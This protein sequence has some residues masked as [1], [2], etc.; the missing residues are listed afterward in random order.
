MSSDIAIKVENLSKI[1]QIYDR[2]QDRLKQSIFLRLNR[3][4]GRPHE[5]YFKQFSAL[6]NVSFE[7]KKGETVGI[8]GQNGSGKS[9]LLQMI[10]GTLNPTQGSISVKG[11][12]AALLELGAGFNTE[13]TGRENVYTNAALLGLSRGE[14][15]CK[16]DAIL[17]FADIGLFID[18]PVKTYSSGMFVR[19]AFAIAA[20]LDPDV[21]IIDEALAVGDMGFQAKCMIRIRSLM[22]R[23][24]TVLFVSHDLASVRNICQKVLWLQR[25]QQIVFGPAAEVADSYLRDMFLEINRNLNDD[26]FIKEKEEKVDDTIQDKEIN[27]LAHYES[28]FT[29]FSEAFK[30]YG[31][32]KVSILDVLLLNSRN[33]LC[34]LL[35][36]HESYKIRILIRA[37]KDIEKPV[38][39]YAFKDLKGNQVL[40]TLST[41]LQDF[42]VPSF[43]SGQVYML[44][45]AGRN[46]LTQGIY[47]LLVSI[48]QEVDKNLVHEYMDVV[49]GAKI[50]R[51]SFGANRANII[52]G[53]V[54]DDVRFTL[55][56]LHNS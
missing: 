39:G 28:S 6:R 8:I 33:C 19:L 14:I 10:C 47:S 38:I 36:M 29:P 27:S 5:D 23:G 37:N 4:F 41:N 16:F 20:N 25:G 18:Q 24:T 22:E 44:E 7:V 21:L 35:E 11:K 3:L 55:T 54:F 40:A 1:Y 34:E 49:D 51:S 43:L 13:F 2:P 45:I 12:V 46:K 42:I 50:F 9:T 17:A 48:E 31:N 56:R 30:R 53:L 26:L 52:H 32:G 15:E